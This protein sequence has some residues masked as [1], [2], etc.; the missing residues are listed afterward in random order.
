MFLQLLVAKDPFGE[1]ITLMPSPCEKVMWDQRILY[2]LQM[3]TTLLDLQNYYCQEN[4]NYFAILSYACG[5]V[6]KY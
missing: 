2:Y 5:S 4:K 1:P 6:P 3:G